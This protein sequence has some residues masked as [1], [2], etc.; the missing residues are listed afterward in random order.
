[1][2]LVSKLFDAD[3]GIDLGS[4][5]TR[6]WI[7]GKG[8]VLDEPSV[9]MTSSGKNNVIAVGAE[10][11]RVFSDPPDNNIV[12][13]PMKGG[14]VVDIELVLPMIMYFIDKACS[15]SLLGNLLKKHRRFIITV[16]GDITEEEKMV[17]E[18]AVKLAA[19]A[20]EKSVEKSMEDVLKHAEQTKVLFIEKSMAAAIGAGL[21]VAEPKGCMVVDVG[22]GTCDVAII[23][24]AGIVHSHSARGVG[25]GDM[26]NAITTYIRDPY[27]L[28]VGE[29]VEEWIKMKIGSAYPTSGNL[30]IN[31]RNAA[32]GMPKSIT[33]TSEEIRDALK[34]PVNKI[35][36]GVMT[37]LDRCE[38]GLA[39][40]LVDSGLVLTGGGALLI[41]LNRRL[42]D[43]TGLPVRM[44]DD[45]AHATIR[46]VAA[47]L[48]EL[49]FLEHATQRES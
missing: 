29:R 16:P 4:S 15:R 28:L 46:G 13:H 6:V 18:R 42:A 22:G 12:V 45:P 2:S 49:D 26:D 33:V 35:V 1:M 39:A 38:P 44:A 34:V 40:D 23:S 17:V 25:G 32:T 43:A 41:G 31:G 30:E 21:P 11:K 5:R 19:W 3:I 47:V 9:V 37:T 8:L 14:I 7:K 48:D 27:H 10:V 24:L 36:E 20:D